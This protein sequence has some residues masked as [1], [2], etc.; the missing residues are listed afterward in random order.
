MSLGI[1]LPEFDALVALHEQD[2]DAFEEF[3][4]QLLR[5]AVAYAPAQHHPK[6]NQLLCR[7]EAARATA[8]T[9]MEAVLVASRM[10]HE[11]MKR[12]Q[13]SWEHAGQVLAELQAA[14]LIERVRK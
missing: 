7:I 5:E 2:P 9:P 1:R 12:L 13:G 4:R 3:R 10:M 11:S 6:L 8:T 14:L